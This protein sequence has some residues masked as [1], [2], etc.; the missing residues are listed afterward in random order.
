MIRLQRVSKVFGEGP[1]KVPALSDISFG[2][3]KGEFV[4]LSGTS[5]AGQTT[6]LRLLR[7]EERRVGKECRL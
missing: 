4:V 1:A 5:G 7:S 2:A 3:D 6:L